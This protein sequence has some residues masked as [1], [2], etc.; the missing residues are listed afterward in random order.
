MARFRIGA[1]AGPAIAGLVDGAVVLVDG[2]IAS[3]VPGILVP[4]AGRLRLVVLVHMS[5]GEAPP[6]HSAAT[7][8]KRRVPSCPPPARVIATSWST[9]ERLLRLY[10]LPPGKV[11]VAQPGVDPAELVSGTDRGG[12]LL[13]VA[14]VTRRKGH[15]VLLAALAAIADLPWRCVCVGPL[16]REPV[17]VERLRLRAEA[18]GIGDRVC[19]PGPRIGDDLAHAYAAADVL[20]LASRVEPYGMVVTEA[21]ARGLPVIATAAAGCRRLWDGPTMAADPA[22]WC[23]PMT[24]L[25]WR[26]RCATGWSTPISGN[27]SEKRRASVGRRC[28]AGMRPPIESRGSSPRLRRHDATG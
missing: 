23:R 18:V 9:R 26:P 14:A 8:V 10:A 15:D 19:F 13:C 16:D 22:C 17:F 24:A 27:A 21:L 5:L 2:L 20:V 6:G 3:T 12:E 4:E 11:H 7:Q 28:P 25:R 1:S